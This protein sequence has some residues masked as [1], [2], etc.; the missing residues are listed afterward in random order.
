MSSLQY[1]LHCCSCMGF[2]LLY[3]REL[4]TA[5]CWFPAVVENNFYL[6]LG[7]LVCPEPFGVV[8][9]ENTDNCTAEF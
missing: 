8:R 9:V 4:T 1:G 3:K 5:A 6:L 2:M 7:I